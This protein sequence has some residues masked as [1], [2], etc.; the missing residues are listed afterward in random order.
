MVW[1]TW[2]KIASPGLHPVLLSE[3][4]IIV[5][6]GAFQKHCSSPVVVE[7]FCGQSGGGG[8]VTCRGKEDGFC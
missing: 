2:Q 6:V 5:L 3:L 7:S 8:H 4:A 1:L